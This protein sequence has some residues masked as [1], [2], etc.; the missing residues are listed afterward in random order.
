MATTENTQILGQQA[1]VKILDRTAAFRV[2]YRIMFAALVA[3][4]TFGAAVVAISS[5]RMLTNPWDNTLP[6]GAHVYAAIRAAQTGDLYSPYTQSPYVVQSYG[7]LFYAINAAIARASH[8]DVWQTIFHGRLFVFF[9]YLFCG[10]FV[11]AISRKAGTTLAVSLLASLMML[12]A[13]DFA[14]WN[15]SVR[16]DVPFLLAM[17]ISLYFAVSDE[18]SD[19][20]S[21]AISGFFAALAFL[22]KQPGIAAGIAI[23]GVLA[24]NKQ[25]KKAATF[26]IAAAVPVTVAFA[27]LL[28][29]ESSFLGQFSS[30]GKATWSLREGIYFLFRRFIAND[31]A[32]IRVVPFC[33]GILGLI[34]AANQKGSRQMLVWFAVANW[35]VGLSGL[36]QL[37]ATTN[38]FMPGWAGFAL[39]L[40]AAAEFARERAHFTASMPRFTAA[41]LAASA[42]LLWSAWLGYLTC[43]YTA[44]FYRAPG[45]VSYAPLRPYR[46]IS[47]RSV[48][49]LYG[50]DP[51]LLDNFAVHSLELKNLWSSAPLAADIGQEKYDLIFLLRVNYKH[52]AT[53]Y[54][55]VSE[56]SQATL[57]AINENY[58]VLCST[59][60]SM[61]LKPRDRE[62]ALTPQYFGDMLH[63]RCGTGLANK[64][65]KLTM[66]QDSQ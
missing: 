44:G 31:N 61:I 19:S 46:I 36:P 22:I 23:F 45:N 57:A 15:V 27:L 1:G 17:L 51:E 56:Y 35:M 9:C 63:G 47:D 49:A 52:V 10:V 20:Y 28:W 66:E 32:L 13:A 39:L 29:R 16:P 6:E 60:A 30:V 33:I 59:M 12:G 58:V 3:Y 48:L 5:G 43:R 4:C 18:S 26:A 2:S 55:G 42:L 65:P 37:G 34:K 64:S 7:P 38:Y 40:P 54:R 14:Y 53:N 11:F 24:W 21:L 25:Y 41:M 62:I 8:L 50:H